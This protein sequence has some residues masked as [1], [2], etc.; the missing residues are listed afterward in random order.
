MFSVRSFLS[1]T[2]SKRQQLFVGSGTAAAAAAGGCFYFIS[3]NQ[4]NESAHL[5]EASDVPLHK[6]QQ[7]QL[8]RRPTF[9]RPT[10]ELKDIPTR[11]EQL[12]RLKQ[13]ANSPSRRQQQQQP[14]SSTTTTTFDVLVIGGGAT[15]AGA[16]LDAQLRGLSTAMIERHDF[17]AETSARSTKLI[18]AGIKYLA[19][20]FARLLD[21][22]NLT[23]PAA[24]YQEFASEFHMVMGCQRERRLLLENNPHLTNWVPIAVPIHNWMAWPPPFGHSLFCVAPLVFPAVFKF[25]DALSGFSCPPS[26]V[27]GKARSRRKFPQ[28]GDEDLKYAQIFYEGQHNDA[29][30][31]T[32]IALTAAEEGA[33]VVNHV[34]MVGLITEDD[35]DNNNTE[36]ETTTGK[37]KKAVGVI[38]RDNLTQQ[39]F[40]VYAKAIIF[41]GGPFTDE[42]RHIEDPHAKPAVAGARG[43]H[44]VLP[45]YYSPSSIGMLDINTSD[46]RFL[47]FLPWQG[48]TLVGTTDSKDK[49]AS[50][51][52][53]P[54]DEIQ[55]ILKEV[56]KYLSPELKVRRSDVLSA[57]QGFRPLAVDPNAEPDAPVSRDHVISTNPVT[58]VTFIT[59]GKWTTV[60]CIALLCWLLLKVLLLLL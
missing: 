54:E 28:L 48:A 36:N 30:T 60:R 12:Q 29:R 41:A 53:P 35:D 25:Y 3:S 45:G 50:T 32:Y 1:S 39:E 52:E 51:P 38:C 33:C 8:H 43:T 47:F 20:A 42:L 49:P 9:H 26:H 59:G 18:W 15:G 57:W 14:S 13:Q 34:E 37:K 55:W 5:E 31:A 11:N 22:R 40:P 16:A 6:Q 24:A 56:E 46:G 27:M 21:W 17:G 58:G 4:K 44:I 23:Q 19:V 2:H 10:V 7:Q